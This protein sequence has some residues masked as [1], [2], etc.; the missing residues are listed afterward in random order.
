MLR[1][2]FDRQG[3]P[4]R[5]R[6][7]LPEHDSV[8]LG[9]TAWSASLRNDGFE[10]PLGSDRRISHYTGGSRRFAVSRF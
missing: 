5:F 10:A 1:P 8:L 7:S 2:L 9:K 6:H 4:S 3:G